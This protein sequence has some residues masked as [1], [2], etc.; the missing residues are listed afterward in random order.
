MQRR[1]GKMENLSVPNRR[2]GCQGWNYADWITKAD[3]ATI[4]YPRGT[5]ANEMLEIYAQAFETVE[6][7]STFYAI[8][9]AA[10]LENWNK[11]TPASFVFSLKMP[12]EITHANGLR[13]AGFAA[14]D[15]FCG[16]I[17]PLKEKLGAVL[18]QLAPAFDASESNV[19]ALREFLPR[20]PREIRFAIEFRSRDWFN[21]DAPDA[22]QKYNVAFC[23]TEGAWIPRGLMFAAAKW[24]T[25]DFAYV[26]FMGERDLTRFD[27]AQR[28]Q[29]ANLEL[30][31]EVLTEIKLPIFVYFSNF[32]EGF[33]PETAN[34][35]KKMF[36]QPVVEFSQMENQLSLF[37]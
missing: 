20:L 5:K 16:Q 26:R 10:T 14:L 18:I 28:S 21:G 19:R 1:K 6:V 29:N 36:Q 24:Q 4:F 25:S 37:L 22:L 8:P 32:Y 30:W 23:L 11:K 15:E 3:G 27:M 31:R 17:L 9:A 13:E 34:K 2:I 7:D 33:A 12:Q 35:L